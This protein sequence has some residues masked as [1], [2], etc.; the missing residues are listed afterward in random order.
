M[1]FEHL[2]SDDP[3]FALSET[4][5]LVAAVQEKSSN[6]IGSMVNSVRAN[7]PHEG[8]R[9]VGAVDAYRGILILLQPRETEK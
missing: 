9:H 1:K 4:Q 6:A 8:A 3:W 7:E 2:K 5:A